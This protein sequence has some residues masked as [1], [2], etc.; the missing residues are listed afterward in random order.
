MQETQV[1]SLDWED[2]LEEE[3]ATHSTIL[4]W[5]IPWTEENSRLQWQSCKESNIH[6]LGEMG[7]LQR[8]YVS[9]YLLFLSLS[10]CV[11]WTQSYRI[12]K[13]IIKLLILGL[14]FVS[15]LEPSSPS[16]KI[17]SWSFSAL[18]SLSPHREDRAVLAS[19]VGNVREGKNFA[20]AFVVKNLTPLLVYPQ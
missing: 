19:F 15:S 17:S 18:P 20:F 1:Q 12:K 7:Y 16:C 8:I 3:M 10:E 13:S 6:M 5:E 11:P 2:P 9:C 14:L 4:A